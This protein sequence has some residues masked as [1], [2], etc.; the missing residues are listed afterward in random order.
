MKGFVATFFDH[1]GAVQ[2]RTWCKQQDLNCVLQPVPRTLSS[3]CGTCA[4]YEAPDWETGYDTAQIEAIYEK[5]ES[6][7]ALL[8]RNED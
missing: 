5:Q 3:S 2:F 8:F 4:V 6:A 1:Y 7:Y